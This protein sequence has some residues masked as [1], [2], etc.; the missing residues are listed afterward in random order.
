[1]CTIFK[2]LQL[3]HFFELRVGWS[4]NVLGNAYRLQQYH[5]H[6]SPLHFREMLKTYTVHGKRRILS[7]SAIGYCPTNC[8]SWQCESIDCRL[9]LK[10]NNFFVLKHRIM[11]DMS[12]CSSLIIVLIT[13]NFKTIGTVFV[14]WCTL[15]VENMIF[16]DVKMCTIFKQLQ[17]V[18]FFDLRVVWSMN[19]HGNAYRLKQYHPHSSP[20]SFRE[21]LKTYTLHGNVEFHRCEL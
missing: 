4:V 10:F 3:V 9:C 19:V 2:Q 8:I 21:M 14:G 15:K 17:L 11:Y 1:M 20:L 16:C 6:S 12:Y 5:P 7:L 18:N 13:L